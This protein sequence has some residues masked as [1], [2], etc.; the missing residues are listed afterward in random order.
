LLDQARGDTL[1]LLAMWVSFWCCGDTGSV[2]ALQQRLM[3][4]PMTMSLLLIELLW[5][6]AKKKVFPVF[7]STV[8]KWHTLSLIAMAAI[9]L[10]LFITVAYHQI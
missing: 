7:P 6:L 1:K 9:P 2:G 8:I 10:S 3:P 5:I 4:Y